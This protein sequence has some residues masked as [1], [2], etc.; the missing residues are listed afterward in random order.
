MVVHIS[1]LLIYSAANQTHTQKLKMCLQNK[2]VL[3]CYAQSTKRQIHWTFFL[4]AGLTISFFKKE[5][6][7]VEM[8]YMR[9]KMT[10]LD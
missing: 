10:V 5:I 9:L 3:V 8:S 7:T 1:F 2:L 4:L 6:V